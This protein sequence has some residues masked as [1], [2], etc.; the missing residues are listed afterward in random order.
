MELVD[1]RRYTDV[2]L[3]TMLTAYARLGETHRQQGH[4][5]LVRFAD[6]MR[7]SVTVEMNRRAEATA[8]ERSR[9]L[10]LYPTSR[11]LTSLS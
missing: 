7:T 5:A 4:Y 2:E 8:Q 1:C 9:Q 11:H 6:N 10:T 3:K